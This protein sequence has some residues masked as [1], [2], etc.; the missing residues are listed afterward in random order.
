M[1]ILHWKWILWSKNSSEIDNTTNEL[2]VSR[3]RDFFFSN[4]NF[5]IE[6]RYI[7]FHLLEKKDDQSGDMKT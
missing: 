4:I 6:N 3:W 2:I 7:T 5:N 1:M